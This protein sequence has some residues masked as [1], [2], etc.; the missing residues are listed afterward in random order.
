M[1]NDTI[2]LK[3][4]LKWKEAQELDE[5]YTRHSGYSFSSNKS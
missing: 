3:K 4:S 5:Q 2:Q 1:T